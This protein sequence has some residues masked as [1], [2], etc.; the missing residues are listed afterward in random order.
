MRA[1]ESMFLWLSVQTRTKLGSWFVS[2]PA[3]NHDRPVVICQLMCFVNECITSEWKMIKIKD[4]W[5]SE[6]KNSV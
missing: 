2:F 5:L 1:T 6:S 4:R 3:R